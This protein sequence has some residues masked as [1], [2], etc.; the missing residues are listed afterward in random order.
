[1]GASNAARSTCCPQRPLGSNA[2]GR[3]SAES[4][5]S[6]VGVGKKCRLMFVTMVATLAYL[7][8]AVPA[9]DPDSLAV[10]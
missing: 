6:G 7:G 3:Q 2:S 4:A 5:A 10:K 9:W 8:L 1:M